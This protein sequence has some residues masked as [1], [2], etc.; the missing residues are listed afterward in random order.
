[1]TQQI[2]NKGNQ[3]SLINIDSINSKTSRKLRE[4]TNNEEHEQKKKYY[5]IWR[6]YKK[7]MQAPKAKATKEKIKVIM[8]QTRKLMHS[9]ENSTK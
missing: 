5:R 9:K 1:M 3:Y 6:L 4:G 2:Y 8:Y 7:K